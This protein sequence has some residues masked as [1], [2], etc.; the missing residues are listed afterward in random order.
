MKLFIKEY[1]KVSIW[2]VIVLYISLTPANKIPKTNLFTINNFDKVVHFGMYFILSAI[3]C[4]ILLARNIN[5]TTLFLITVFISVILGGLLEI[6]QGILPINRSCSMG[7][8]IA[9]SIGGIAGTLAYIY[10]PDKYSVK[11]LF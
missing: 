2:S 3:I 7:D 10:M 8:F 5:K 11:N 1:F 4:K 9:N 6:I